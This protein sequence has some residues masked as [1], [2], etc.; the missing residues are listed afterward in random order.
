MVGS[1]RRRAKEGKAAAHKSTAVEL[2]SVVPLDKGR[3]GGGVAT[4][5]SAAVELPSV[6]PAGGVGRVHPLVLVEMLS[7][8]CLA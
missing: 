4:H 3:K 2:P 6:V 1:A 7:W 8:M 5:E